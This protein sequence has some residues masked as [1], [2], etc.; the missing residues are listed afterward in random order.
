MSCPT[1]LALSIPPNGLDMKTAAPRV[2]AFARS[3]GIERAGERMHPG[4]GGFHVQTVRWNRRVPYAGQIRRDDSEALGEQGN[5]RPQH[6]RRL[7]VAMEQ[8]HRCTVAG[9]QIVESDA[10][11]LRGA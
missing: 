2:P 10:V 9:R 3:L 4:R 8:D 7:C 6:E 1:T 11:D 5:D